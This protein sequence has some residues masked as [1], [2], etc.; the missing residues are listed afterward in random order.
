M[1]F[2][3]NNTIIFDSN[4]TNIPQL[5]TAS[6]PASPVKGQIVYNTTNRRME[7]YDSDAAVWKSAEDIRRSVFLT[8]QTI[9]TG[10]VMGGY[11][12]SSPWRNVNRMVHATDVCTNLGDLLSYAGAYTSGACSISKGFLW[13]TD[14]SFPG[15]STTTSAFNLAA[16][17]TAGTSSSWNLKVG[18]EDPATIFNQLEWAFI[19]GGANRNDVEQ[20]NLT[21]ETMLTQVSPASGFGLTYTSYYDSTASAGI[22]GEEHAYVYGSNGAG[23]FVFSTG[24]AYNIVSGAYIATPPDDRITNNL[25]RIY[26]PNKPGDLTTHAQQKGI[27]S[28]IG[29]GWFG[30]EGSYNGGYNLRRIQFST[31]S[32][33]GTVAKPIG[34][35]GEENFDMGQTKQYMLGCYDG[36]QNNRTWRFT[37]STES[38][39]ELG[40]GSTRTGV[41]GGSSG[42]CVW[43]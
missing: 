35:S 43:K 15:S 4:T 1:A 22:S 28:K 34:N 16:E 17:T 10:Y 13:S 30:N 12:N 6:L 3:D 7:I 11:Q 20:F 29:R 8:R 2:K 25:F 36:A 5:A 27:N 40:A 37:Y 32:S 41:P 26:A 33:L 18:R 39:S 38:G 19:V 14:N 21:N 23:K 31:D 9:T 24:M 42:H